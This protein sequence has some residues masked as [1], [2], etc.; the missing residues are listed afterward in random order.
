MNYETPATAVISSNPVKR[1]FIPCQPDQPIIGVNLSR[2]ANP[3]KGTRHLR[4]ILKQNITIA[5]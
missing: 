1:F 3:I 2:N 5:Y 4:Y